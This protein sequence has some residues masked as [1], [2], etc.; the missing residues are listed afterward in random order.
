MANG[1][2][3]DERIVLEALGAAI[4]PA[5]LDAARRD[6][7]RARVQARVRADAI[8]GTRTVRADDGSW[9]PF[10][11]LIEVKV[12]HRDVERGRETALYRMQPGAAFPSHAHADDEE[13]LVLEGEVSVGDL[14]LRAGDYHH[15]GRGSQHPRLESRPGAL[16][17]ISCALH[18]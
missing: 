12:L 13:C 8:A 11:P 14:C 3:E 18:T 9:R 5:P 2:G 15:A 16:L 1:D 6:A 7:M 17:L 4:E 10:L